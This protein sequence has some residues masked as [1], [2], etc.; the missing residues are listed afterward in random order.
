MAV[1]ELFLNTLTFEYP[2]EPVK[3]YFSVNDDAERKSTR[4]ASTTLVPA[5]IK[6]SQN[7]LDLFAGVGG[8]KEIFTSFD[9]PTVGFDTVDIDFS[10]PENENLV[11]RYYNHR[12]KKYFRYYDDV[13]ITD[14]GIT[15]DIQ[16]WILN[17]QKTSQ[18]TYNSKTYQVMQMDRYTLKVRFDQFNK[19]PYLLVALDRPAHLLNIPLATLLA[20]T[21]DDPF[22]A[23]RS[24]TPSMINKVMTRETRKGKDGKD[25][26][27]RVIDRYEYLQRKNRHCPLNTTRPILSGELKRFFGLD[28][29][30]EDRSFES[31]Y[32]NY[33]DQIEWF[34][35]KYLN[36]PDIEKIFPNLACEFTPVSE[37]QVGQ[38]SCS[39]RMLVFGKDED[40]NFKKNARQQEGVNFGPHVKCPHTDVQLIFVFPKANIKEAQKL[41]KDMKDGGYKNQSKSLTHYIGSHVSYAPSEY[42]IQFEDT[43]N[44]VPEIEK[45]LQKDCY[46]SKDSKVKYVAVYISPIHKYASTKDTKECYY[47]IKELFLKHDI[48]TQCIDRDKMNESISKDER[49]KKANFVYTLQNMSVAICAKIGGS[50]WLLDETTKK[51]LVIGIGAFKTDNQQYIGAAFSFDNT[52]IFNDYSYFQK[53]EMDELVGAIKMAIKRYSAANSQPERI[54]IHY[55][56]KMSRKKEFLKIENMLKSLDLDIPVYVVTINK[57]ESEDIV[58]FD[59]NSTYSK[60]NWQNNTFEEKK[61]LMPYS[62]RWINLGA[63]GNSHTFLLCN[64]TRYENERFSPMDGF[65]FPVELNIVCPNREEEIETPVIQQLIDQ[66]YQFSRIYWKSVKQQGLPVTIKYPEMIAEI[67]PHFNDPTVYTENNCLWFL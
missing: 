13:V 53:S 45:A 30:D 31:K 61:S 44:P 60:K 4:L 14:Y 51:E 25:F 8:F 21:P 43:Y 59:A 6:E 38:T 20:E 49:N 11:K 39:K 32:I 63:S 16:I 66:V 26:V 15:K 65:P 58:M 47:K 23:S 46:R 10:N 52:G 34:R 54:I 12:L 35:K 19:R 18:F 24:V 1:E 57:T 40:G 22:N 33:L 48:P 5:E 64:N 27:V 41:I 62:G 50:P 7:Y 3:F 55:Y 56:K 29:R 28:R 2:K 37:L 17:K 67:M 42:H 36:T 9:L